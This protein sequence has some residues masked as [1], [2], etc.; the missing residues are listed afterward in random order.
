MRVHVANF[1][2]GNG[3]GFNVDTAE[4]PTAIAVIGAMAVR[5]AAST[6]AQR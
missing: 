2:I 6:Q 4:P 3:E 5:M 1:C